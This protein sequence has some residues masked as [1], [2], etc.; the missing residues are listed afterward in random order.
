MR[1]VGGTSYNETEILQVFAHFNILIQKSSASKE[2][3]D[4]MPSLYSF[5]KYLLNVYSV[6]GCHSRDQG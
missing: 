3:T 2:K 5:N 6:P 1:D 4:F